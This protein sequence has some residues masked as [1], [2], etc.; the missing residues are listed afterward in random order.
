MLGF[1]H[2]A[3]E[4]QAEISNTRLTKHKRAIWKNDANG[5]FS[6]NTSITNCFDRMTSKKLVNWLTEKRLFLTDVNN[7]WLHA[8]YSFTT[9]WRDKRHNF[10][11]GSWL[12][13]LQS[14]RPRVISPKVMSPETWVR[15]PEI[16]VMSPEKKS[17]VARRNN[18][19]NIRISDYK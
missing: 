19:K 7:L 14:I 13:G 4:R 9:Y 8:Y 10:T 1:P 3:A 12:T 2:P 16:L 15:L 11:N 18:T 5:H 6:E 17:Q